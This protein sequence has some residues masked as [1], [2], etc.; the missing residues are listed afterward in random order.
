MEINPVLV[1]ARLVNG[2]R[3]LDLL[4]SNI[5]HELTTNDLIQLSDLN[6]QFNHHIRNIDTSAR[7]INDQIH[8]MNLARGIESRQTPDR[9]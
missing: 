9:R 8:K 2:A 4:V 3:Q 6:E 1:M 7:A 5:S